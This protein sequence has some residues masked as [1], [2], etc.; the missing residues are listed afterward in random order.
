MRTVPPFACI[1]NTDII[2]DVVK[3]YF[4]TKIGSSPIL[5]EKPKVVKTS[6]NTDNIMM[7][8]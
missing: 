2:W 3:S 4:D 6:N 1:S 5:S 7:V 8:I